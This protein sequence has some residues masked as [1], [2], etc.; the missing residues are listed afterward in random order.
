MARVLVLVPGLVVAE[1]VCKNGIGCLLSNISDFRK[2]AICEG[3]SLRN[4]RDGA[5]AGRHV[6]ILEFDGWKPWSIYDPNDDSL[7]TGWYG[8]DIDLMD[9]VAEKLG[10]TYE[11][12]NTPD[13]HANDIGL[14]N[15]WY[16]YANSDWNTI[17]TNGLQYGDIMMQY[18][19][20]TSTRLIHPNVTL[21]NGHI[22]TSKV[23]VAKETA[24][25]Q[26][27]L[28]LCLF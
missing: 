5:L 24:A 4:T 26:I 20:R 14:E 21:V 7:S 22:D 15:Y 11:V 19:S 17:M 18:W 9:F 28:L 16:Y 25:V 3:V 13:I 23:L 1:R 27:G 10:I 2:G 12:V 8:Y 6:R